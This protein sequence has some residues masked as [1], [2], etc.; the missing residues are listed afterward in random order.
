MKSQSEESERER[1]RGRGRRREEREEE[2]E[3]EEETKE[4]RGHP[5]P[6]TRCLSTCNLHASTAHHMWER[7]KEREREG[8]SPH[9]STAQQ[10]IARQSGQNK[11][12]KRS[13]QPYLSLTICHLLTTP[14]LDGGAPP[15]STSTFPLLSMM[16]LLFFLLPLLTPFSLPFLLLIIK[17]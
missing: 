7:Q 17:T 15:T 13:I 14:A 2:E 11:K 9:Y 6:P 10:S 8:E 3:E 4:R 1:K 5:H 12:K 16:T